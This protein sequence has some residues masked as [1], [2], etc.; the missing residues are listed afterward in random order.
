MVNFFKSVLLSTVDFKRHFLQRRR[1]GERPQGSIR[2]WGGRGKDG[3]EGVR[4]EGEEHGEGVERKGE[5]GQYWPKLM[6]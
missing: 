1:D 4:K 5:E 3:K 2:K 6:S